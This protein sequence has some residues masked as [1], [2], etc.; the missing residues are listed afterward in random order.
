V[1]H[2]KQLLPGVQ[3]IALLYSIPIDYAAFGEQLGV[4]VVAPAVDITTP[5]FVA[6]AHAR[7]LKLYAWVW[8]PIDDDN[9]R[10]LH[11][12]GADAL[13]ADYIDIAQAIIAESH[14]ER[15]D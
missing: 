1:Y 8:E 2:L 9:I 12:M 14:A 10:E 7:G 15:A 3:T 13:Y 4:D 5:E 11:A 6:D